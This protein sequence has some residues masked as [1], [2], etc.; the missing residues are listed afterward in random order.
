MTF[1]ETYDETQNKAQRQ[2]DIE[3]LAREILAQNFGL[4]G[5]GPDAMALMFTTAEAFY[6]QLDKRRAGK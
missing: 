5:N 1:P 4:Y 6:V 2:R 3:Q